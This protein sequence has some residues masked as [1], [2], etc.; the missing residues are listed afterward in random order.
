[1]W[2][3]M[4]ASS[5]V[6]GFARKA[7][8]L[9]GGS[10]QKTRIGDEKSGPAVERILL[11]AGDNFRAYWLTALV[12]ECR[13]FLCLWSFDFFVY[14]TTHGPL[15]TKR[16]ALPWGGKIQPGGVMDRKSFYLHGSALA[17]AV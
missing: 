3:S 15:P 8:T 4:G 12:E 17:N 13:R 14:N 9:P 10:H 1:M 6:Y 16:S 7:S 2:A 5:V 11:Y